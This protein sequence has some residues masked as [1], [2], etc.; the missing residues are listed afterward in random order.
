MS[1]VITAAAVVGAAATIYNGKQ[2]ADA[3][4]DASRQAQANADKQ[5]KSADEANNRANQKQP[6]T[7]AILDAANQAG[8]AGASGTMLT[9]AQGV[10]P[11]QLALGKSTLLG[12]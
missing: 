7:S 5:M 1:G 3:A 12:M 6:D 11:N 9:G 10:D 2:Q 8:K 4:K